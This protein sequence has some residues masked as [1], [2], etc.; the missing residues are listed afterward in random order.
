MH[1]VFRSCPFFLQEYFRASLHFIVIIK[2]IKLSSNLT[3]KL[4]K[5][6]HVHLVSEIYETIKVLALFIFILIVVVW[7][8]G[9]FISKW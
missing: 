3:L 1:R 5:D 8:T 6:E 4:L 7:T 9:E 2:Y